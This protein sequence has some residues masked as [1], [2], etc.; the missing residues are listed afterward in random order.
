[1]KQRVAPAIGRTLAAVLVLCLGCGTVEVGTSGAGRSV[2]IDPCKL[3]APQ[4]AAIERAVGRPVV[5]QL[6]VWY[7]TSEFP[8]DWFSAC[9]YE[10]ESSDSALFEVTVGRQT[11]TEISHPFLGAS[12]K[13]IPTLGRRAMYNPGYTFEGKRHFFAMVLTERGVPL[14]MHMD[15]TRGTEQTQL[16]T[17]TALARPAVRRIDAIFPGHDRPP[18]TNPPVAVCS[19]LTEADLRELRHVVVGSPPKAET[20][21]VEYFGGNHRV[22]KGP[23]GGGWLCDSDND[24]DYPAWWLSKKAPSAAALLASGERV[25]GVGKIAVWVRRPG[26]WLYSD[27]TLSILT[28]G[29]HHLEIEVASDDDVASRRRVAFA[30]ARRMLPRLP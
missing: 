19:L 26:W 28:S 18:R 22:G 9:R 6:T 7:R 11:R 21:E 12:P 5:E 17:M 16:A 23:V 13:P 10:S 8:R 1:M 27:V 25:P 14:E 4:R 24:L 2:S 3:F 30:A 29:G 20:F 15:A